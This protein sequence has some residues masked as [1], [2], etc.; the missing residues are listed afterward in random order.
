VDDEPVIAQT[1][2]LLLRDEH[3]VETAV[4]AADAL[5]RLRAGVRFDVILCDVMMPGMTGLDLLEAIQREQPEQA[6]A[7]V[8]MTG[9]VSDAR[10]RA[11]LELSGRPCFDKPIDLARVEAFI[12]ERLGA[13]RGGVPAGSRR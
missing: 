13:V 5:E 10:L 1:L 7:M 2:G 6:S 4:R 9:G 8:F 11:R 3:D 12:A